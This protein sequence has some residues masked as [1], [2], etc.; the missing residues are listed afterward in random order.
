M[1]TPRIYLR[2]WRKYRDF[3]QE[4]VV[5]RL[6][7]MEDPDIPR[8]TASLS[9]LENGKQPYSQRVLEALAYVYGTEPANLIGVNPFKEGKVYDLLA[10]MSEPQRERA[11]A[12]L[13]AM[14]AA[15]A[16]MDGAPEPTPAPAT[17]RAAPAKKRTRKS[18]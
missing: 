15:D 4:Q 5:D 11:L 12:M 9:R 6:I 10:H 2:E 18:A 8:T 3:T 1:S 17:K 13:E 7:A 16:R 14:S